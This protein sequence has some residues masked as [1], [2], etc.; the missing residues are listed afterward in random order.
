MIKGTART[1]RSDTIIPID[2]VGI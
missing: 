1:I 2:R